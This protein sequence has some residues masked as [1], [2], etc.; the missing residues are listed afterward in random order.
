MSVTLICHVQLF[1]RID[2]YNF[3]NDNI[4]LKVS[5]TNVNTNESLQIIKD[6][7]KDVQSDDEKNNVIRTKLENIFDYM[8]DTNPIK[9]SLV[10]NSLSCGVDH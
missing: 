7:L 6:L 3:F 1:I 2:L 9:S 4:I 5:N 8:I 10:T